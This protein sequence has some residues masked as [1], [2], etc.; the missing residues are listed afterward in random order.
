MTAGSNGQPSV[1]A[2]RLGLL[3]VLLFVTILGIGRGLASGNGHQPSWG[4]NAVVLKPP[5]SASPA[6]EDL[7]VDE[8]HSV[9]LKHFYRDGGQHIPATPTQ[10]RISY[11]SEALLVVFRCIED[12]L[13]FPVA[14]RNTEDWY[15]QINQR[16]YADALFP[17]QVDF[18]IQP[19]M[20]SASYYQFATTP[21]GK[22]LGCSRLAGTNYV[23]GTDVLANK[24][25]AF[26]A[27]VSRRTNEWVALF[28]IPWETFGGKPN[29][30]FGIMPLRTRWRD[31]EVSSPVAI[32]FMDEVNS[33]M[34]TGLR[35]TPAVDLF[36][37]THFAGPAGELAQND[38]CRLPSGVLR[39][40][41][42]TALS[43]PNV[44]T[45]RQIW[46]MQSSLTTPTD[47][48]NL[49]ERLYLTRCWTDLLTLEGFTGLPRAWS[50]T[51]DNLMPYLLRRQI[52]AALRENAPAR[53]CQILDTYLGKLDKVS[54][55]WYADGSPGDIVT[56]EWTPVASVESIDMEGNT[57]LMRC[58]A[59]DHHIDLNLALPTTGGTRIFGK[60]QGYFKPP[61]LLPLKTNRTADTCSIQTSS[62]RIVLHLRPFSIS[63][64]GVDGKE[65]TQIGPN[66]LA[67]RF[68]LDGSVLAFDFANRLD[69]HE[70][71]YG[72]GER[73]DCFNEN[74]NVVTLWGTDDWIGNG[75]GLRNT[76]YKPL[77][78]FHS[79]K[80]YMV[81]DNSTYRLRADVGMTNP[82]QYRITQHG[83]IFDFY[84][85]VGAPK[86][87]L[88]AY[89]ALTGR[90]P[91]PPKWV[92]EPWMGRGESA[93]AGGPLHNPVWEETNTI[94]R[95]AELDVP[96]SAI[97]AEGRTANMPELHE[98][99]TPR[100]IKI[101][102]YFAPEMRLARQQSL[103]PELGLEEIPILRC[104]G[105]NVCPGVSYID[106]SH[107]QATELIRRALKPALELGV[108]GSMVDF[109]DM[110][111]DEAVFYDGKRGD[112]MH[113][114]YTYAYHRTVSE[115]Y[116]EKRG[117]DFIL[118]G[119][120]ASPGGQHW[121]GQ[122][123]GDHSGNFAGLRAVLT[124]ALNL[125]ACGYSTWGSDVCGYFGT[126]EPAVY[127]RWFQF[128]CFSP[129]WR[130]HGKTTRDPWSYG[131]A[132][133][134]NYKFLAWTRENILNYTY[135]AAV[136]ANETGIPIIRS[137][138]I[139]FPDEQ[140]LQAIRDQYMF[141]DDM[142]VAPVLSDEPS[143]T[144]VFPDGVWTSLWNG[145]T[146]RGPAQLK[147]SAPL[148]TIPVY[149]RPGAVVSVRLSPQLQFGQS[150]SH[151]RVNALVVTMPRVNESVSVLNAE[152]QAGK[153]TVRPGS[154][155]CTWQ[156]KVLPATDYLLV[157]GANRAAKVK[158]GGKVLPHG[159][160]V[161]R[162]ATPVG[163]E[164]DATGN[165]LIIRLPSD[166]INLP[167]R[168][169]EVE[170]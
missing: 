36:I 124:G 80:G 129:I 52:N 139:S 47:T 143:R 44:E 59:G 165:R 132:A 88:H 133:V 1:S 98:F 71:I 54:R 86:E 168:T 14:L 18:L 169:I 61:G 140:P 167:T 7:L 95:F 24:I 154:H 145:N 164:A 96:H 103:M 38:L 34:K 78:I 106:F 109:G 114:F 16:K 163:W 115:I 142:L 126:P 82:K 105:T 69:A 119:R 49:A 101:L 89:T 56:A 43:Y 99:A 93:W 152:G 122:F 66:S 111:P 26:E 20:A 70:V 22:K 55:W 121:V 87:S 39:W 147:V 76:T 134:T 74:G 149:L 63:F 35:E 23:P 116:R 110:V 73:Y 144:I 10:C 166:Q 97:Y 45:R 157:Y 9:S 37:E 137:M 90:V 85:Y 84:F 107:P 67:F 128:A 123:A 91:L 127:I 62:G 170:F 138:P 60:A 113:N 42:P 31:G 19:D 2:T 156:L 148:D 8:Q 141:G 3:A 81:F 120:A 51:L 30:Y 162:N 12:N 153:V 75:V 27:S 125:C 64:C 6:L 25:E 136:I 158:V 102:G 160:S 100:E 150:M 21:D 79:S 46:Q 159:T 5:W 151:G 83:P 92:F 17:D 32:D 112:E 72:F 117:D 33:T 13:S 155:R 48:N 65:V 4:V 57:L 58:R 29:G 135:N 146:V 40:Q 108:S 11:N 131:E 41:R 15:T 28:R 130:P 94:T 53:A 161:A 68:G 50:A 118:Y 104:R 77:P